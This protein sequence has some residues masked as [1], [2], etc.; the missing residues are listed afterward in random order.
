MKRLIVNTLLAIT[1]RWLI[2]AAN[3]T[4]SGYHVLH[5]ARA[6]AAAANASSAD[7]GRMADR[8]GSWH[9][10]VY[11]KP[12]I[13]IPLESTVRPKEVIFNDSHP[14][15]MSAISFGGNSASDARKNRDERTCHEDVDGVQS[16][17]KRM[18]SPEVNRPAAAIERRLEAADVGGGGGNGYK[19]KDN[20]K[21]RF[22]SE[23]DVHSS[24]HVD[25]R[26]YSS[27]SDGASSA[28]DCSPPSSPAVRRHSATV[29]DCCS[30]N[31]TVPITTG[32][33]TPGFV[34]HPSGA[35]YIPV[36]AATAELRATAPASS[37]DRP[38]GSAV[39]CHP[40]SIPVRFTGNGSATAEVVRLDETASTEHRPTQCQS[41]LQLQRL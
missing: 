27:S 19:Y 24:S 12:E 5:T 34:L 3:R 32:E 30:S 21:Q 23:G 28:P 1:R 10:D 31:R 41:L 17:L 18:N 25:V 39:I 6:P 37:L 36:I 20:I 14:A 13:E 4:R 11:I 2:I 40:V 9:S 8:G 16:H 38:Q 26:S 33:F 22:C 29:R 15:D 35:Y 7:N